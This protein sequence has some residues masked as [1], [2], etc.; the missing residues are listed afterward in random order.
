VEA[1][2][3]RL[4]EMSNPTDATTRNV[5]ASDRQDKALL[6]RIKKLERR[7]SAL[8]KKRRFNPPS[9]INSQEGDL[10]SRDE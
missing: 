5:K 6:E 10:P 8:E 9:A 2:F 3:C 4:S 7:V 1:V